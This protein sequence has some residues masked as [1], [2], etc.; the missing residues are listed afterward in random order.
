MDLKERH[1]ACT[2]AALPAGTTRHGY[3]T[4]V[5]AAWLPT[6]SLNTELHMSNRMGTRRGLAELR[7]ESSRDWAALAALLQQLLAA[8]LPS[9]PDAAA[10]DAAAAALARLADVAQQAAT[11]AGVDSTCVTAL[12]NMVILADS[13]A[14]L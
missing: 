7:E 14:S 4:I 3:S 13:F 11:P 1:A 8:H 9:L 6:S 10:R 5:L 2:V 12:C